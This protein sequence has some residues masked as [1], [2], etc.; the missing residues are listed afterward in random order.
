MVVD[1][2]PTLSTDKAEVQAQKKKIAK[3]KKE[4]KEAAEAAIKKQRD[5]EL[6]T[7]SIE[8][9]KEEAL[10]KDGSKKSGKPS[11]DEFGETVTEGEDNIG[12]EAAKSGSEKGSGG[13]G[14]AK[15]G[16]EGAKSGAESYVS[17]KSLS[18]TDKTV[19]DKP[20]ETDK[21]GEHEGPIFPP[22]LGEIPK[23]I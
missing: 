22:P 15:S 11:G 3:E 16:A 10:S 5:L 14:G 1:G 21:E 2:K 6:R 23:V 8:Q 19:S 12:S 20:S 9:S 17:D 4:Q 18:Y 7:R 13:E